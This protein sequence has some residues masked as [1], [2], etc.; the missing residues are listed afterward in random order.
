MSYAQI[1]DMTGRYDTRRLG[2]LLADDGT[3]VTVFTDNSIL[4][5]VLDEAAGMIDAAIQRGQRYTPTDILTI[6]SAIAPT[7]PLNSQAAI[8]AASLWNAQQLLFRLN[9]DLAYGLLIARRGMNASDTESMAP[10]YVEA[11]R[12]LERLENGEWIF[13]TQGALAAGVPIPN[14]Q[15][16]QNVQLLSSLYRYF[17]DLAVAPAQNYPLFSSFDRE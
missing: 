5:M 14:I 16:S 10:R 8:T 1:T 2:D 15:I 4:Q 3:R 12:L 13:A 6:L 11:M 9:C 7:P 17:G